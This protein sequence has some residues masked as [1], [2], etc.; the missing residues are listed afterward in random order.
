MSARTRCLP[1]FRS[2]SLHSTQPASSGLHSSSFTSNGYILVTAAAAASAAAAPRTA[3]PPC[4]IKR[5]PPSR[6]SEREGQP[7]EPRCA[8]PHDN[9]QAGAAAEAV[10][11]AIKQ[12]CRHPTPTTPHTC[13]HTD[14]R[15]QQLR[16]PSQRPQGQ[17]GTH[18]HGS[19][20]ITSLC[21]CHPAPARHTH[22][23]TG[24]TGATAVPR[25]DRTRTRATQTSSR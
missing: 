21:T 7:S 12:Q 4:N 19:N 23:L 11:H 9:L 14:H 1:W 6:P 24:S 5:M 10:D 25:L 16:Q 2:H 8:A 20:S 13:A 15:L 22:P 3:A 18:K 17:A